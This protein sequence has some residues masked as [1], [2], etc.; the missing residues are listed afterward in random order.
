MAQNTF[1]EIGK[2]NLGYRN[3]TTPTVQKALPKYM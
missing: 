1:T 3:P 2:Y